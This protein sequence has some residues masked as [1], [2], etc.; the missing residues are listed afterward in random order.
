M[1]WIRV[2]G[3][4]EAT[5][6]LKAYYEQMRG[7]WGGLDHILTIHSLNPPSLKAHFDLYKV[8]MYGKS[9]LSRVQ[10]EMIA[11]VVSAV[12]HCKY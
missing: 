8:L 5:G 7:R 11:T 9:G 2:I 1:A 3:E 12:N 10:R 4:D 6:E